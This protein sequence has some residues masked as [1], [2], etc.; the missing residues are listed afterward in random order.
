[1]RFEIEPAKTFL[2]LGF[3]LF[4]STNFELKM[5]N[6]RQVEENMQLSERYFSR[7]ALID[8]Y[9]SIGLE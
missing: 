9:V 4:N 2:K 7:N 5:L 3:H 6:E 8:Q 1:M